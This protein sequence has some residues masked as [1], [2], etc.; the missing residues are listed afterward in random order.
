MNRKFLKNTANMTKMAMLVAIS[1]ILIWL[2][3]IPILPMVPFLKYDPADIPIMIGTLGF[4]TIPGLI[5]TVITSV[6][7]G[8]TIVTDGGVYG[9]IMHILATGTYVCVVGF[10]TRKDKSN[11]NMI[12]GLILGTLVATVVM[13]GLNLIV[14]PLF[15][16]VPVE[17]VMKLL[18]FIVLFNLI[19]F[20][21]NSGFTYIIYN[22]IGKY[23]FGRK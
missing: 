5:L 18:K 22:V 15:L 11:K 2:I 20:G 6:I 17:A 3:S 21:L 13:A 10:L 8:L 23:L 14:T 1:I 12:V 16:G 19:K 9:I 7:Q 4:G